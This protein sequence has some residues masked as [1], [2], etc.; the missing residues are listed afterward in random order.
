MIGVTLTQVLVVVSAVA[1]TPTARVG[2]VTHLQGQGPNVLMGFGLVNGLNKTGD[3]DG[4]LPTMRA[5]AK[6][7]ERFGAPVGSLDDL[8]GT[9]NVAIVRVEVV[10]PDGG[11]R[12]GERLDVTVTADAAKSLAGGALVSCPLVHQDREVAGLFATASGRIVVDEEIPTRGTI[13]G[14]A[15][16]ERDVFMNVLASGSEL[17]ATGLRHPWIEPDERY[18]T[19]VLDEAHAG[20]PMAAAIAQALD[21]GLGIL[22]DLDRVALA[23]DSRNIVVLVPR[24]QHDDVASWIRDVERQDILMEPNEARVTINR[25]AGTIVFTGD[26]RLSP[27]VVS[28]AGMT[29]TVANPAPDGTV[30]RAAFEQ[31][32]FVGLELGDTPNANVGDLLEA[33]NQLNVA[34]KDRV[35]IIKE[36]HR[37]GKLHARLMEER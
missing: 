37:A 17:G 5:L 19:L 32:R 10:I 31:H 1:Q 16:M 8:K 28:Q 11:A 21:G 27:V 4:Y 3:G 29:I 30:P 36:I 24:A 18:I 20:W 23:V 6:L 22:A 9:K 12:E 34:F 26:V 14:G 2:D 33:L 35:S 15:R 7:N 25:S 13:Y